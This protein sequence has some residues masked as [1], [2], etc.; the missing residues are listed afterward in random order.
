MFM[1]LHI[2]LFFFSYVFEMHTFKYVEYY[3]FLNF[4]NGH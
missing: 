2:F 1:Y 4:I 3:S